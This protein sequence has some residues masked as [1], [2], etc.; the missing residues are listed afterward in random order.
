MKKVFTGGGM[1]SS[2]R[3]FGLS[4]EVTISDGKNPFCFK[5]SSVSLATS[6]V[7]QNTKSNFFI[8][9]FFFDIFSMVDKKNAFQVIRLMLEDLRQKS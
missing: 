2:F 3:P 5:I 8:R 7:P 4:G 1:I 6:G 9:F